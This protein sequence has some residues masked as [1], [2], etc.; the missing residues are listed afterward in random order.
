[1]PSRMYPHPEL[2]PANPF[3]RFAIEPS[4]ADRGA[5][6]RVGHVEGRTT[7]LQSIH[8]QTLRTRHLGFHMQLTCLEGEVGNAQRCRA[9]VDA[10]LASPIG[11]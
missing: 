1:M 11:H 6:G 10:S 4:G 5:V 7:D 3:D 8:S 2:A 9:G